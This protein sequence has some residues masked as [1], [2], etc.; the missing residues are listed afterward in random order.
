MKALHERRLSSE[1]NAAK[2]LNAAEP[3]PSTKTGNHNCSGNIWTTACACS[4][5]TETATRSNA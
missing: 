4:R 3:S 2:K 5:R 1:R